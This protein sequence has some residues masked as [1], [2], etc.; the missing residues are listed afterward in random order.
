MHRL[1]GNA[2][3]ETFQRR[4]L[5][6]HMPYTTN[7]VTDTSQQTLHYNLERNKIWQSHVHVVFL[8]IFI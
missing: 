3:P 7:F 4:Q 8:Y 2:E 6:S 5:S 1:H